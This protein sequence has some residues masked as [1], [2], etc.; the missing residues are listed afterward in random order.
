MTAPDLART[1]GR[2]A[3]VVHVGLLDTWRGVHLLAFVLLCYGLVC[4]LG[5][6][7]ATYVAY[8]GAVHCLLVLRYLEVSD[9]SID[10]I[11]DQLRD[12]EATKNF[13]AMAGGYSTI[14][15]L[16]TTLV[17]LQSP[18][19]TGPILAHSV[20]FAFAAGVRVV[21]RI[22][23]LWLETFGDPRVGMGGGP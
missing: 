6:G 17:I 14:P 9:R 22:L 7:D 10:A 16:L 2:V 1:L 12:P 19:A 8:A 18:A 23:H 3:L 11:A 20:V 5:T 13:C 15:I 4:A 21:V